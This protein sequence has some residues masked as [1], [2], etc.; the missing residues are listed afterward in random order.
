MPGEYPLEPDGRQMRAMGAAAVELAAE[1]ISDI[2]EM[3]NDLDGSLEA[4]AAL[5]EAAPEDGETL[6]EVLGVVRLGARK[7]Y[8]NS[9][10]GMLGYVPGSGLYASAVAAFLSAA[11]NKY[12][13]LWSAVPMYA[14]I[15]ATTVRWLA[16]MV[17]YPD[18]ARGVLTSGGTTSVFS[19]LVTARATKLGEDLTGAVLYVT[20]ETHHAALK[21]AMLAGLPRRAVRTVPTTDA[22]SMDAA[23]LDRMVT[24]DE[25]AGLRPFC[26]VASAG[27]VNTGE[28]DPLPELA[29]ICRRHG[30]WLHVDGAY[31]GA[32]L[33]TERGREAM[34]GI[35]LADSV[36]LDPHKGFF[37]PYGTGALLVRDGRLLRDAHHFDAAYLQDVAEESEIPNLSEYSTELSRDFRGLRL[38]LPIKLYGL[39]AF[40]TALDEKLDLARYAYDEL[41][42]VPGLEVPWSPKLSIVAFRYVPSSGDADEANR[43]LLEKINESGRIHLSSTMIRGSFFLR[44]C[45]LSFRT[46]EDRMAEA[47]EI[48]R[49]AVAELP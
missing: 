38:W 4:A 23:A 25:A 3:L 49:K 37:L 19:G 12:V 28:I 14:Q 27:T 46:H 32:F 44:I 17:G 11:T 7:S 47:I 26:V 2:P 21:S 1:F 34:R 48:I 8:N 42:A 29:A 40:R 20:E 36:T 39:A 16:D 18:S 30:L 35:E 24:E 43:L 9:G 22:L 45:V 6:E 15:E 33:L 31:G 5:R 10:P 41:K 13:A